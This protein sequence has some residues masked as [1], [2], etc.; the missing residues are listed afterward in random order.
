MFSKDVTAQLRWTKQGKNL[1][2]PQF[3][4]TPPESQTVPQD[5]LYTQQQGARHLSTKVNMSEGN[6]QQSKASRV[7]SVGS[8]NKQPAT[9]H[10][11][12]PILKITFR[13][14]SSKG[15]Q[16]LDVAQVLKCI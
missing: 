13:P 16:W 15:R 12:E 11:E 14:C 4:R 10:E 5:Q 3:V 9:D 6:P 1:D 8:I 7:K 2:M